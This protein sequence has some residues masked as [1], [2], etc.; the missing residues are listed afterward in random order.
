MK[1]IGIVINTDEY[2]R[3]L[4]IIKNILLLGFRKDYAKEL[5]ERMGTARD[6]IRRDLSRI[7]NKS[8][9]YYV[10]AV[11]PLGSFGIVFT[12]CVY[13]KGISKSDAIRRIRENS[14]ARLASH[15]VIHIHHMS[16]LQ[17]RLRG[18]SAYYERNFISSTS[19]TPSIPSVED[20][21][22]SEGRSRLSSLYS[23]Y[24]WT[25]KNSSISFA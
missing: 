11:I 16:E 19:S 10:E 7:N 18:Y 15:M 21:E 25:T 3:D 22:K 13:N 8:E 24:T 17:P 5:E 4:S 2:E 1:H 6:A 14:D 23:S 20:I 9:V 12:R